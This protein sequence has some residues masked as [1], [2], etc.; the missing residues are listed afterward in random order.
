MPSRGQVK[1]SFDPVTLKKIW[2]GA[3]YAVILPAVVALLEY[4][5]A[6]DFGNTYAVMIIGWVVPVVVN[7]VKEWIKGYAPKP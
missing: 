1:F 3:L 6:A 5:D 4:L 7:V 2:H